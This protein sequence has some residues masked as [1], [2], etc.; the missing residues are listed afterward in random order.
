MAL[1]SDLYIV[2]VITDTC[3]GYLVITE[4]HNQILTAQINP[5]NS[6]RT[7]KH[8]LADGSTSQHWIFSVR[9]VNKSLLT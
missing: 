9:V 2:A 5:V 1:Y 4:W 3:S 7:V 6:E 8:E